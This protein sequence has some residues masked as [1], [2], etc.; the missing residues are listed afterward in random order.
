MKKYIFAL[1]A[2]VMATMVS[3]QTI[4]IQEEREFYQKVYKLFNDYAQSAA[5][6]DDEEEAAF[7]NL[8]V[9]GE[10]E[11]QNDLMNLS[12]EPKLTV[13]EYIETIQKARSVK[14]LV[15]NIK[16]D[17]EVEDDGETWSLPVVF[18][19]GISFS[20]D[21]AFFD[22][23]DYFGGYYRLRAVVSLN[24]SSGECYMTE[25][26]ADTKHDWLVF[27]EKF[28]VLERTPEEENK[29][30][31]KRDEKLTIEGRDVHWNRYN[32][33]LL[34]PGQ[35][36]KIRYN[37]NAVDIKEMSKMSNGG[38]KIRAY[39][40]DKSFRIRGSFGYSLSGFN[41]LENAHSSISTPKDD[42]MSFGA[43]FGYV[44]P[45]TSKLY[46]G[47]FAGLHISNNNLTMEKAEQDDPISISCS[48][49]QDEDGESYTRMYKMNGNVTQ[50]MKASELAVPIYL[51]LEYQ[52]M[53][54]LSVYADLGVRLQM[55]SGKWT[56]IADGYE[57]WGTG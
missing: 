50:E 9:N 57:T 55:T 2:S 32:Q 12:R 45:S 8:F 40:S 28:A 26:G 49:D 14:V 53:P 43:D 48:G 42:E 35:E 41:K 36:Q 16:K 38:S 13:D 33:V 5:V 22:S 19:K 11:I 51:D 47:I 6:S 21:G 52:V 46:V 27:P 1:I 34:R 37:D 3:A 15:K 44:F 4:T 7:R 10:L 25:L 23:Y 54:R 18:E 24:K 30:N 31:F 17:G 29:R 56:A 20:K 39:Y